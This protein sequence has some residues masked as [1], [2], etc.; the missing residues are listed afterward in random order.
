MDCTFPDTGTLATIGSVITA[1]SVAMLVFRIQRELQMHER[2][3]INWL[4]CADWLLLGAG[5]VSLLAV[6]LP[7][8]SAHPTSTVHRLVPPAACSVAVVLVAGY[9]FGILA[10]YRLIF[11]GT[12]KGPRSNPEPGE[13]IVVVV[14]VVVAFVCVL[15]TVYLHML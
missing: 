7:L 8:V 9:T 14:T 15:W 5:L 12:R 4:P 1:F 10:H 2:R 6:I 13:K 3:E 11:G